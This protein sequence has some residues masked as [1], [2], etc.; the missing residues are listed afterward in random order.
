M[1][2]IDIAGKFTVYALLNF[3]T[4]AAVN[5]WKS[6]RHGA[7]VAWTHRQSLFNYFKKGEKCSLC[8]F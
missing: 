8:D 1:K 2:Y 5:E 3:L 4:S 6:F 7:D